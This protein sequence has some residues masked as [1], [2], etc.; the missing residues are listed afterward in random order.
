MPADKKKTTALMTSVG[1]DDG[2][3]L[4]V[5]TGDSI[6][7]EGRDK[8]NYHDLGAGYPKYAA[9]YIKEAHPDVDFEF[10]NFGIGGNRTSQLFDRLY[11]DGIAFE[12]D[13]ISILIGINDV[14]HR[15]SAKPVLTTDEQFE[16]NLRTILVTLRERTS[17]K[18]LLLQPFLLDAEANAHMR[19]EL[20]RILPIANRLADEYAEAKRFLL[21]K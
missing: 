18:I 21:G 6:T 19:P 10:I 3:S 15:H 2:R 20:E 12:P 1:A 17:A 5:C 4:N 11:T 9:Q 7:D 16:V 8:R 13:I 14:W